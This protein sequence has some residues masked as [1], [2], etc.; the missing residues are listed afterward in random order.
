MIET[1]VINS[2]MTS[3]TRATLRDGRGRSCMALTLTLFEWH[4]K[5][6]SLLLL[7]G[8]IS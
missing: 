3:L 5:S 7:A 8:V 2:L 1:Q 4:H 6:L